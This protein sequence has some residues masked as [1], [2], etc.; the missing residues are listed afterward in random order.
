MTVDRIACSAADGI[1]ELFQFALLEFDRLMAAVTYQVMAVA[2]PGGRET[3]ASVRAMHPPRESQSD[4]QVQGPVDADQ[5]QIGIAAPGP[6]TKLFGGQ[7]A[8]GLHQCT[9]NRLPRTG[10][11]MTAVLQLAKD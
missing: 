1:D 9:D 7:P 10:T 6:Q 5:A 3:M 11:A 8:I 2:G 4:E